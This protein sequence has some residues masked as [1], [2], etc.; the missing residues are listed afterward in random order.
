MNH[1]RGTRRSRVAIGLLLAAFGGVV[2]WS[3][4]H[5]RWTLERRDGARQQTARAAPGSAPG[6]PATPAPERD[7]AAPASTRRES[8]EFDE[9]REI[10][11]VG[12]VAATRRYGG[13]GSIALSVVDA[14]TREPL[15][16]LPVVV[17]SERPNTHVFA[18]GLTDDEGRLLVEQLPEDVVI[19]ETPRRAPHSNAIA[20]TWL[21]D[22]QE[23]SFTMEV[24]RGGSATGR[25]VD[26][27][28]QPLAGVEVGVDPQPGGQQLTS[29]VEH[30]WREPDAPLAQ[31]LRRRFELLATTDEQGRY[32]VDALHSRA[33]AIW[34]TDDG[35]M[36]PRREEPLQLLFRRGQTTQS[37]GVLVDD[38]ATV[39]LPD[40]VFE[41]CRTY[42]GVVV[43]DA[44]GA[45]IAGALV[46]AG[47]HYGFLSQRAFDRPWAPPGLEPVALL[48]RRNAGPEALAPWEAGF[49]LG[50]EEAITDAAGRFELV[51]NSDGRIALVVAPDWRRRNLT[52]PKVAP[53]QRAEPLEIRLLN[54][55]QFFVHITEADGAPLHVKERLTSGWLLQVLASTRDGRRR[56][57]QLYDC[58]DSTF[59][60][61][62]A[63]D[64]AEITRLLVRTAEHRPAELFVSV[65]PRD[66]PTFEVTLERRRIHLL[67]LDLT[68]ADPADAEEVRT[69]A[70][71]PLSIGA[72]KLPLAEAQANATSAIDDGWWTLLQARSDIAALPDQRV[73]LQLPVGGPWHVVVSGPWG[74]SSVMGGPVELGVFEPRAEPYAVTLPPTSAAWRARLAEGRTRQASEEEPPKPGRLLARFVDA[75]TGRPIESDVLRTADRSF[76]RFPTPHHWHRKGGIDTPFTAQAAPGEWTLRFE[77]DRYRPPAP[78]TVVVMSEQEHDL[79][80]IA[81]ESKSEQQL[82]V[83]EADGTS[84]AEGCQVSLFDAAANWRSAVPLAQASTNG[85]GLVTLHADLPPVVRL[86]LLPK[87]SPGPY[88]LP[89]EIELE[90]PAWP[91]GEPLLLTLP[92][93]VAMA[94]E[95][96]QSAIDPDVR[97]APCVVHVFAADGD[98]RA[99]IAVATPVEPREDD[100]PALRRFAL[101][102]P[103][104]RWRLVVRSALL[105]ADELVFEVGDEISDAIADAPNRAPL[106]LV[107]RPR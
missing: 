96:D 23:K 86:R 42:E 76:E 13:E 15:A 90:L 43:D 2:V 25:V 10:D 32:Q 106:R 45:P 82:R 93:R 18:C 1:R 37:R 52:L 46:T 91:A 71:L 67:T 69:L 35:Q 105:V 9:D 48:S 58:G 89:P 7:A 44:T 97:D 83:L 6:E 94:V 59:G 100:D 75:T 60:V 78:R 5:S 31:R 98:P 101:A 65:P 57:G 33:G 62:A 17:W 104:G 55:T 47:A 4:Y 21:S 50:A 77:S 103:P 84:A 79:G 72:M 87:R 53:G 16:D 24:G 27:L 51:T 85:D 54:E 19:F 95:L 14:E 102:L 49:V 39:E 88:V 66:R 11:E 107:A 38:G 3:V 80:T 22:G 64:A 29:G 26:D 92:P 68:V 20:A 56:A 81:L 41:R 99:P 30:Q 36:D 70:G 12:R 28:G 34:I 73:L 74:E 63:V 8:V 61:A 40:V